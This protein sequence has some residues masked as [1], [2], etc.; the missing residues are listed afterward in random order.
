MKLFLDILMWIVIGAV[1]ATTVFILGLMVYRIIT[2]ILFADDG[3]IVGLM[4]IA[5]GLIV[6]ASIRM[7]KRY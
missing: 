6:W 7:Q 2:A 1:I 5:F 3:W 4:A